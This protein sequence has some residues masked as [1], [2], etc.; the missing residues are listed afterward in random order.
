MI[1]ALSAFIEDELFF[2]LIENHTSLK[3]DNYKGELGIEYDMIIGRD[4]IAEL[5][6]TTEFKNKVLQWYGATVLMKEPSGLLRKLDL[7]KRE[8]HEVVIQTSEPDSTTKAT[9]ILVK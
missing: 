7:N 4:L 1:H 5:V 2:S 9:E 3:K 6:P 8:M